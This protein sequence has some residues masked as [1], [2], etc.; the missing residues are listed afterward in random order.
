MAPINAGKSNAHTVEVA[1]A[2]VMPTAWA[3]DLIAME[4]L[5][6]GGVP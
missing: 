2:V 5:T 4:P 6:G 3:Q 1:W